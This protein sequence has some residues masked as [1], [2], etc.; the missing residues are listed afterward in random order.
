M[1]K[2]AKEPKK[3]N[4][5]KKTKNLEDKKPDENDIKQKLSMAHIIFS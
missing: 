5:E 3:R 2:F 4:N 1:L